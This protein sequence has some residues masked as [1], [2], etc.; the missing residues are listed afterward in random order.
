MRRIFLVFA[1]MLVMAMM[2]AVM[3]L[4]AVAASQKACFGQARAADASGPNKGGGEGAIL[5]SRKG[6]NAEQNATFRE[7][8]QGT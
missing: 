5:S 6:S 4:P 2:V 7:S 8:C 3:A 1:A